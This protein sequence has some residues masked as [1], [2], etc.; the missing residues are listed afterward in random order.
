MLHRIGA[1]RRV[2]DL[3]WD[4]D[5][6][7]LLAETDLPV[8]WILGGADRSA[9]NR[10]TIAEIER[11]RAE[12]R[13]QELVLFPEAGHGMVRSERRDGRWQAVAFEPGYFAELVRSVQRLAG[14]G[15]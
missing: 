12:G 9:P 13:P 4:Y 3:P 15:R 11:L 5:S 10:A 14:P 7:A 8:V 6:R 2:P 1:R